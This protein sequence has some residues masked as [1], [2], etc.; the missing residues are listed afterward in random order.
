MDRIRA[1]LLFVTMQKPL[2]DD[3][4]VCWARL[5]DDGRPPRRVLEHGA[6]GDEKYGRRPNVCQDGLRRGENRLTAAVATLLRLRENTVTVCKPVGTGGQWTGHDN[7][8]EDR[9]I[10]AAAA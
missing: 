7:F 2:Q 1:G 4:K 9:I 6:V 10:L 5:T 3:L 8:C